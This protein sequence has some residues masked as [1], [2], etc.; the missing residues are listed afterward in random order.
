MQRAVHADIESS[1]VMITLASRLGAKLRVVYMFIIFIT[2][3][4][5]SEKSQTVCS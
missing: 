2:N 5:S 1:H 3:Q 4:M